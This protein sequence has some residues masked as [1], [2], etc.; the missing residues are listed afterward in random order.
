MFFVLASIILFGVIF[1]LIIYCL[2]KILYVLR[3]IKIYEFIKN[4]SEKEK[5]F[6]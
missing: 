2:E 3:N 4:I 1:V 5:L 6:F